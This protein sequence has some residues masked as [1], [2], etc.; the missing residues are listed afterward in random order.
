MVRIDRSRVPL[1]CSVSLLASL[2]W[3]TSTICRATCNDYAIGA[4]TSRSNFYLS[5]IFGQSFGETFIA[6]DTLVESITVWRR[7]EEDTS[8]VGYS[9][10]IVG[11]DSLGFPD[12][13]GKTL[14]HG[15]VVYNYYGDGVHPTPITFVFDPPFVLPSQGKYEFA[16]QLVPCAAVSYLLMSIGDTYPDGDHWRHADSAMEG[17]LLKPY[18]DEIANEDLIFSIRFCE[19]AVPTRVQTWGSMRARYR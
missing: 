8:F 18:P 6:R 3:A 9:L 17:C 12:V 4:D 1:L 16:I 7:A 10:F 13:T 5:P 19:Q 15:R 2:L 11:T 14:L